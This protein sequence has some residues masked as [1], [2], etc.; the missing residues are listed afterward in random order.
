MIA[1]HPMPCRKHQPVHPQ[2][3][4]LAQTPPPAGLDTDT[5]G[6]AMT[7]S[8]MTGFARADGALNGARWTWELKT[9]NARGLD[10]RVRVPAGFDDLEAKARNAIAER[11]TRGT[12]QAGLSITR[13]GLAPR[14]QV[15]EAVLQ[16]VEAALLVLKTRI[17]ATPPSL[18]GLLGIRGLVDVVEPAV[19]AEAHA[20]EFS[21][22]LGTLGEALDGLEATRAEEGR[23][24]QAVLQQRLA[25][26]SELARAADALPARQPE[27][28][29]TRLAEQIT[30]LLGAAPALDQDRLHQEA[31]L[32]VS[33][34]DVREEL[35]RLGAHLQAARDLLAEGKAVGRRLDFL[36][37]EFSRETNTLCAKSN[38]IA[39]TAIGLEL[40][41]VVE[42]FREQVQ[43]VE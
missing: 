20:A 37:Q 2:R 35:D 29:R 9:V 17:D 13:E 15:N 33:K 4:R 5:E 26:M 6:Q 8:S 38:D 1:R 40:K 25:S 31:I 43:N 42:Q 22:I 19:D 34:A 23:A 14:L 32:L 12:C 28:I 21:A 16:S 39:L 24:L 7:L 27:A 36:C 41:A 11:L 30:A 18:D 3:R 10:I